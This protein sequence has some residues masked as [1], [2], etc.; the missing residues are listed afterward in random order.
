MAQ[1]EGL[2]LSLD[3]FE[4]GAQSRLEA[5]VRDEV[6]K[7]FYGSY[8]TLTKAQWEA[9][10]QAVLNTSRTAGSIAASLADLNGSAQVT[11]AHALAALRAVRDVC[12]IDLPDRR[13]VCRGVNLEREETV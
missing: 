3:A 12:G 11:I 8:D 4:D 10:E 7:R 2:K 6:H 9:L 5:G 1:H 13:V